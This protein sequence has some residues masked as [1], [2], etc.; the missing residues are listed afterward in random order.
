MNIVEPI[1]SSEK[2]EEI[3]KYLRNSKKK[4]AERDALLFLIGVYTRS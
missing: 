3:Y 1:R 2:V 4:D